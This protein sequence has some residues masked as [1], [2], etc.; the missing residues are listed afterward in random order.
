MEIGTY[1]FQSDDWALTTTQS[2]DTVLFSAEDLA[3]HLG[4]SNTSQMVANIPD[5]FVTLNKNSTCN[6]RNVKSKLMLTEQGVYWVIMR[7]NKSE[8]APFRDWVLIVLEKIR[9]TGRYDAAEDAAGEAASVG[10]PLHEALVRGFAKTNCVY[11]GDLGHGIFKIG[12]STDIERRAKEQK[13][14]F[15]NFQLVHCE[16]VAHY[17]QFEKWLL[18]HPD[19]VAHKALEAN[20]VK[21]SELVKFDDDLSQGGFIDLMKSRAVDFQGQSSEDHNKSM[22]IERERVQL[23]RERIWASL[24]LAGRPPPPVM[25]NCSILQPTRK[26]MVDHCMRQKIQQYSLDLVFIRCFDSIAD[27]AH[28]IHRNRE[29]ISKD[30]DNNTAETGYRWLKV[31]DHFQSPRTL[32][33]TVERVKRRSGMVA[34]LDSDKKAVVRVFANAK[35]AGES[36]S[37]SGDMISRAMDRDQKKGGYF[38]VEWDKCRLELK[39]EYVQKWGEPTETRGSNAAKKLRRLDKDTREELEVHNTISQATRQFGPCT[40]TFHQCVAGDRVLAGYRWEWV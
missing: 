29:F 15:G 19:V 28:E 9:K 16:R 27:A 37:F 22:Q 26:R 12:H 7:S 40:K 2:G 39:T 33:P 14:L 30:A 20:G 3:K 1:V 5:K 38:W 32:S 13:A 34:A 8:A 24:P 21:C 11:L 36:V 23:E 31:E 17:F 10:A 4:I 25:D 18:K 35:R 6:G